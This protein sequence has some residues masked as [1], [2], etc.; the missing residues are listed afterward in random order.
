MPD[1]VG[2]SYSGQLETAF[3]SKKF[4]LTEVISGKSISEQKGPAAQPENN[5]LIGVLVV[6][7]SLPIF[8][9]FP[10]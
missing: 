7:C 10:Q 2:V 4:R 5:T 9:V 3:G 8:M 1:L 6:M